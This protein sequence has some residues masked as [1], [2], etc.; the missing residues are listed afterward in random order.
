MARDALMAS[1]VPFDP[2][3]GGAGMSLQFVAGA[4]FML[5]VV[6][7]GGWLR[8]RWGFRAASRTASLTRR[9]LGVAAST[10]SSVL[11]H[12]TSDPRGGDDAA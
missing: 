10:R 4:L 6:L 12:R 11:D 3:R 9:R 1:D 2:S 5:G 8:D 7:I